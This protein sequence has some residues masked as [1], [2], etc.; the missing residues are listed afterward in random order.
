MCMFLQKNKKQN[1]LWSPSEYSIGSP[2]A[3]ALVRMQTR[4]A[5]CDNSLRPFLVSVVYMCLTG[6]L[7]LRLK[8]PENYKQA[9]VGGQEII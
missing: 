1:H 9:D 4:G 5:Q 7:H 3:L 8:F 2:A 6:L